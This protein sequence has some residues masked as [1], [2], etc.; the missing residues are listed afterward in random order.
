L[1]VVIYFSKA[2][3]WTCCSVRLMLCIIRIQTPISDTALSYM[4][5]DVIKAL[6]GYGVKFKSAKLPASSTVARLK[7]LAG[8]MR[9]HAQAGTWGLYDRL[10]PSARSCGV[11]WQIMGK[12]SPGASP[13]KRWAP[14]AVAGPERHIKRPDS[15]RQS[16]G[17]CLFAA[18]EAQFSWPRRCSREGAAAARH[19]L[20]HRSLSPGALRAPV[21]S[22][23]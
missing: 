18:E 16:C 8:L 1:F 21:D 20:R 6:K 15:R 10:L 5:A 12:I 4:D 3:P 23:I 22:G 13:Q 14:R 11:F 2:Y 7:F 17:P 19:H 9:L